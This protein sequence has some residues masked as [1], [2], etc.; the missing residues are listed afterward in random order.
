MQMTP[1]QSGSPN[2]RANPKG[3]YLKKSKDFW[4]IVKQL[5]I[6]NDNVNLADKFL[7]VFTRKSHYPAAT[8]I[9]RRSLNS[10]IRDDSKARIRRD[11]ESMFSRLVSQKSIYSSLI[12]KE[13]QKSSK[14]LTSSKKKPLFVTDPTKK[15]KLHEL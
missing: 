15:P 11:N 3:A 7:S 5:D 14:K 2:Q 6:L 12:H 10:K 1:S 13:D 4:N 8:T 9:T